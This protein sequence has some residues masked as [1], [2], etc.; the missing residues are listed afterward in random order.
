M[1]LYIV[2]ISIDTFE[3]VI[4]CMEW[5]NYVIWSILI[6]HCMTIYWIQSFSESE[7]KNTWIPISAIGDCPNIILQGQHNKLGSDTLYK[8]YIH[9]PACYIVILTVCGLKWYLPSEKWVFQFLLYNCSVY[10]QRRHI[11]R[12]YLIYCTNTNTISV[13][14]QFLDPEFRNTS[15]MQNLRSIVMCSSFELYQK[16]AVQPCCFAGH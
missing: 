15:I 7:N 12:S 10:N 1:H 14:L 6:H 11:L 4:I 8:Y 5:A 16:T 3:D 2:P 9:I 13:P